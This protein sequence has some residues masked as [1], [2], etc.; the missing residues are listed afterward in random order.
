MKRVEKGWKGLKKVNLIFLEQVIHNFQVN[1]TK[2]EKSCIYNNSYPVLV[3]KNM[4][5]KKHENVHYNVQWILKNHIDKLKLKYCNNYDTIKYT[6]LGTQR[7]P[8][9]S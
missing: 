3:T 1:I 6:S 2:T 9:K 4:F 8:E 7:E 5:M